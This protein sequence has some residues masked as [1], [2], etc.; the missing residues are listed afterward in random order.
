MQN[1]I[2]DLKDKG[3]VHLRIDRNKV[4]FVPPEK[5]NDK[6]RAEYLKNAERSRKMTL[7][8]G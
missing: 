5:A 8:L 7:N 6:Y 4:L 1:Y 3:L 2:K